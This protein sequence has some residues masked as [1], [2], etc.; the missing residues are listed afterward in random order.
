MAAELGINPTS[1]YG[2]AGMTV[3]MLALKLTV[4]DR[5]SWW[6]VLLPL[7]LLVGFSV[8]HV[9]VAF[10]YLSF[11]KIPERPTQQEASLLEPHEFNAH[12][13]AALLFFMVFGDNAVRWLDGHETSHW[14]W[15]FSG[16]GV[17]VVVFGGLSVLALFWYWSRLGRALKE[18]A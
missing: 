11:A 16:T 15:L 2:C 7:G 8:V 18:A 10:I 5:W 17:A 6:R 14:F 3:L 9:L 4:I 13:V 1:V 12:Y